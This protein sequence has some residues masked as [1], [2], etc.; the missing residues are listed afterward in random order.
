MKKFFVILFFLSFFGCNPSPFKDEY[1][2][3]SKIWSQNKKNRVYQESL[4]TVFDKTKDAIKEHGENIKNEYIEKYT[5]LVE[6]NNLK[7]T[8]KEIQTNLV[9][10]TIKANS[11]KNKELAEKITNE[12]TIKINSVE[13]DKQGKVVN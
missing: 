7:A 4:K 12:I 9:E 5:A 11:L 1:K 3:R 8:L 10:V 2:E 6:T 13:F